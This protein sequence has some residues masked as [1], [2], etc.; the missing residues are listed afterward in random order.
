MVG[1]KLKR[2]ITEPEKRFAEQV[3][4][5]TL[6]WDKIYISN[7]IGAGQ[8]QY[9]TPQARHDGGWIMHLG[10]AMYAGSTVTTDG[11][12]FVHELTHVWQSYHSPFR[13]GYAAD[14]MCQQI[15]LLKGSKAYNYT[16]GSPWTEYHAEQQAQMIQDWY[17]G[18][19]SESD[20]RFQYVRDHIR[21]GR[22]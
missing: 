21:T 19:M 4:Q 13:W 20:D 2:K 8:R 3:F 16:S 22:N 7:T 17:L 14:S 6:P 11:Y 15:V 9:V 5:N 1:I 10:A 12:I 18:G